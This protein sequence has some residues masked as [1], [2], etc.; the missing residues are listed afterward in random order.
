MEGYHVPLPEWAGWSIERR[1]AE[2]RRLYAAAGYSAKHPL[3]VEL[4]YSTDPSLRDLF[5]AMAAMWRTT[6]GAEVEPYN[7]EFRVMLQDLA[8]HK[9]K[10]FSSNWIAEY[11]DPF[12]F[13][14]LYKAD[15]TMN[16]GAYSE[17]H[18]E[19]LL[20][21]ALQEPNSARR[22]QLLAEAEQV[23]TED[24]PA[25]PLLYYSTPHLV[26]P[27]LKGVPQNNLDIDGSRYMY[28]LEHQGR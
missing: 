24:V 16:F 10:I 23:L 14:Q 11:R 19:A 20:A 6:L 15:Y 18:F 21:S 2:A 3:T 5:D 26:K 9:A 28:I 7:E 8:L 13:L 25:I 4:V 12:T 1:H 27:Y 17:P 22:Y